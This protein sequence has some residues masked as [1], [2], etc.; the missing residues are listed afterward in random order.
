MYQVLTD[1]KHLCQADPSLVR[2]NRTGKEE[3]F[4]QEGE[5][6]SA[7]QGSFRLSGKQCVTVSASTLDSQIT[8]H[9]LT[10]A[11]CQTYTRHSIGKRLTFCSCCVF[12]SA[13]GVSERYRRN[14]KVIDRQVLLLATHFTLRS[15]PFRSFFCVLLVLESLPPPAMSLLVPVFRGKAGRKS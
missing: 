13:A 11:V 3:I 2:G 6:E 12:Y 8:K 9:T 5:S 14:K 10:V 7:L 4:C 1:A 15:F